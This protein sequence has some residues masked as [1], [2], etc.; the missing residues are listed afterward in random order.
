[1]AL[2]LLVKKFL[3]APV[4]SHFG[5]RESS[6]LEPAAWFN[7]DAANVDADVCPFRAIGVFFA[8]LVSPLHGGAVRSGQ[9]KRQEVPRRQP[10]PL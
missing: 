3:L 7:V 1:M 2:A 9:T 6:V 8:P 5:P 10:T 4:R